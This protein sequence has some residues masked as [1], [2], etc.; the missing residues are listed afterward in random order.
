MILTVPRPRRPV[1]ESELSV[2]IYSGSSGLDL[3]LSFRLSLRLERF[4]FKPG[5]ARGPQLVAREPKYR[6]T[7]GLPG[8]CSSYHL[9]IVLLDRDSPWSIIT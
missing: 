4:K 5:P 3:L 2:T 8:K 6:V 7:G 9:T 1:S